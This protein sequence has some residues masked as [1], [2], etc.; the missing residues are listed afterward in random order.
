MSATATAPQLHNRVEEFISTLKMFIDGKWVRPLPA[1]PLPPIIPRPAK[2]WRRSPK[3]IAKT[4]TR[5]QGRR[6]AFENGPWPQHDPLGARPHDLEARRPARRAPGRIR[7]AGN[8]RQRQAPQQW[9]ASPTF[10]LAVD[11]FRYMA[12]WATKIEGNTIPDLRLPYAPGQISGLHRCASL[13][14]VVGQIIP[15]NFPLLMAAW[16]LGPA[17]ATGCTVV[18]KPAEQTPLT[19]LRLAELL[20]KRDFRMAW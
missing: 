19:A 20:P 1:R 5:R 10:P 4:S 7:A 9:R 3:A 13:I 15:W 11:L 17:L 6:N 8:P 12:G 18:L 14:G 2:C 16:K